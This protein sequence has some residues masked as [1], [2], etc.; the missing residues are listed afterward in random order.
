MK[1]NLKLGIIIFISLLIPLGIQTFFKNQSAIEG[2]IFMHMFWIFANFL[3][4]STIDE[5]FAEYSKL[6]RLKSLKINSLNY[7]VKILVYVIFLIFLNLYIVRTMYL[8]EHKLLTT[9]TNPAV[10][11]LIL[12]IFLVNLLSGLFENKEESKETNVY[13]FS[14]KNSFRTGRDTFNVAGGT[15]ADGFILGNLVLPYSSIKSIYTDKENRL[16]IKGKKEDG[17]Y[18]ISIDSEKTISFFKNLLNK[19]ISDSKIDSKIV[20][21]R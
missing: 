19:A 2:S 9:V 7:I 5:L 3:F 8:P 18:R 17:N 16:V 1:S 4:L 14:N 15:Y 12:L 21:T 13:T 10:V 6:T 11:A 20:K